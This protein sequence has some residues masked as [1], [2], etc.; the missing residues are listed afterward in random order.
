MKNLLALLLF[1][2][3]GPALALG[4]YSNVVLDE[5]GNGVAAVNVTVYLADTVTLASLYSDNGT[6]PI[7]NPL[8]TD[9]AG[10]F[11][12]WAAN[13][14]YDVCYSKTGIEPWCD[15]NEKIIDAGHVGAPTFNVTDARFGAVSGDDLDD[16]AAFRACF[17]ELEAGG[18]GTLIVPDGGDFD[19][20]TIV[21]MP[22]NVTVTGGGKITCGVTTTGIIHGFVFSAHKE[23]NITIDG[24]EFDGASTRTGYNGSGYIGIMF[25]SGCSNVT[26]RNCHIYDSDSDGALFGSYD[27]PSDPAGPCENVIFEG[28][29]VER[30]RRDGVAITDA[31]SVVVANNVFT[32]HYGIAIDIEPFMSLTQSDTKRVSITGNVCY[33]TRD[34]VFTG[35]EPNTVS[36]SLDVTCAD[37]DEGVVIDG[38][39]ITGNYFETYTA[40]P[41]PAATF[42]IRDVIINYASV[43]SPVDSVFGGGVVFSNNVVKTNRLSSA[44]GSDGLVSVRGNCTL[45]MTGNTI[46]GPWGVNSGGNYGAYRGIGLV[47]DIGTLWNP[48]VSNNTIRGNF[49]IGISMSDFRDAVL[50]GNSIFMDQPDTG[51]STS[52]YGMRFTNYRGLTVTG[53]S[54]RVAGYP[55]YF[56]GSGVGE[57]DATFTGVTLRSRRLPHALRFEGDVHIDGLHF[58]GCTVNAA[59]GPVGG[60]NIIA[61]YTL[62]GA[63]VVDYSDDETHLTSDAQINLVD[64]QYSINAVDYGADPASTGD[65]TAAIQAAI[66]AAEL[67]GSCYVDLPSGVFIASGL[68]IEG[69]GIILRGAGT[70]TDT[71]YDEGTV[72]RAPTTLAGNYLLTIGSDARTTYRSGVSGIKFH[73]GGGYN[74]Q[75]L[76]LMVNSRNCTIRDCVFYLNASYANGNSCLVID[77][78]GGNDSTGNIV[79][80]CYFG[81][82]RYVTGG[83]NG[84]G[85]GVQIL[86][87]GYVYSS[88]NTANLFTNCKFYNPDASSSSGGAI[89]TSG[90]DVGS[91]SFV[92]CH[93]GMAATGTPGGVK[94]SGLRGGEMMVN[95]TIDG[96]GGETVLEFGNLGSGAAASYFMGNIDGVW[97][98]ANDAEDDKA[99]VID[100][101]SDVQL[102]S[103]AIRLIPRSAAPATPVEGA[104][105]YDSD[106]N[107]LMIY[108]DDGTPAWET[109]THAP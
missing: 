52:T 69:D 22:S 24:I 92:N 29:I 104:I 74:C 11:E 5:S 43:T 67:Y 83:V 31:R 56:T 38:V 53:G 98:D 79:D 34:G 48:V 28:N 36:R 17:D 4:P 21:F 64:R 62:T 16:S 73:Y 59:S 76:V 78:T 97:T 68:T 96:E 71:D 3:A 100:N 101:A 91:N 12:F 54:V 81:S 63:S 35:W 33:T 82:P 99:T 49:Q 23:S 103:R 105:Y 86:C 44:T 8:T 42:Y 107:K 106:T 55:I 32:D 46:E 47:G 70:G 27:N 9:Y 15:E 84:W 102:T 88:Y 109:V 66:D 65:D 94:L 58:T 75:S 7:A 26:V 50:T 37:W 72:I 89:Y 51:V 1:L 30:P 60:K 95:C 40:T 90:G 18:G 45:S 61:R 93:I 6:T 77:A 41:N 108:V 57:N 19:I 20:N 25:F 2:L 10:R 39:A 85:Y 13:G 87:S 14:L 80:G